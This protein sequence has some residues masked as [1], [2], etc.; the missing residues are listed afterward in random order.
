MDKFLAVDKPWSNLQVSPPWSPLNKVRYWNWPGSDVKFPLS[1]NSLMIPYI[2]KYV[3]LILTFC[4]WVGVCGQ[5]FATMLLHLL[6]PLIL[7]ATWPCSEKVENCPFHPGV[8][9]KIFA[10]LLLHT[11]VPLIW[12]ATWPCS[13]KVEIWPYPQ[14]QAGR[15]S[16]GKIFATMLLHT[17][18]PLIW[19]AS[20]N[21]TWPCSEKVERIID[22]LGL[23]RLLSWLCCF[24]ASGVMQVVSVQ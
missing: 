3:S 4:S 22:G 16:A 23:I 20:Y 12:Y 14:G 18:F 13:E 9:G 7:Y 5:K 15:G 6:F 2:T 21:A 19:Y 17:W 10:T 8:A 1:V 11:W 24:S